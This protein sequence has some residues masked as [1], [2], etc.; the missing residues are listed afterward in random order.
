MAAAGVTLLA[1]I[2]YYWASAPGVTYI[3]SGELAANCASLG[4]AH[5]TGYPLYVCLGRLAVLLPGL[6]AI[7]GCILL[8]VLLAAFA[9]GALCYLINLTSD[10]KSGK[11]FRI[12]SAA[13]ALF[14]SLAPVWWSQGTV[15]EVYGLTLLL[16]LLTLCLAIMF[17][18]QGKVRYLIAMFY[19]WGLSLGSHLSS[20]FLLPAIAYALWIKGAFSRRMR[21]KLMIAVLFGMI[22]LTIYLYLPIRSAHKPFLNWSNPA[23]WQGFLNHI[24]G[25][26][27]RVWM[28]TS[29]DHMVKGIAY[30]RKLIFAQ[31]GL[32]GILLA[33][34]GGIVSLRKNRMVAVMMF[35]IIAADVLYSANYEIPDIDAYYLIAFAATA[36]LV[37]HGIAA[38]AGIIGRLFSRNRSGQLPMYTAITIGLGICLWSFI[39]GIRYQNR[40]GDRLAENG[41][42]NLLDSCPEKAI[43][44]I[45]NWDIYSPW[46]Y[47]R[48]VE[49]R[50]PDVVFI[51][52]ELLRRSW[53]VDFLFRYHPEIMAGARKAADRFL[54]LLKPFETGGRY[55]GAALTEAMVTLI[56]AIIENNK[57]ARPICTNFIGGQFFEFQ[58]IYLPS[59][60]LFYLADSLYYIPSDTSIIDISAWEKGGPLVDNRAKVVLGQIQRVVTSRVIYC[61]NFERQ[62]ESAAWRRLAE[63]I[64]RIM[65]K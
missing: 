11:H 32:V 26:Q 61:Q 62:A 28:F 56:K 27:Y 31:I 44:F 16:N 17:L 7:K 15:N 20:I 36:V 13:A 14:I 6:N 8:S 25:W 34:V 37:A 19:L 55:D 10:G 29:I 65:T 21:T 35:L 5:P 54:Q 57:P 33:V 60:A 24:T 51:D 23:T 30:F 2:V 59:G 42:S 43:V 52:K 40:N 39:S 4:I 18:G 45:E 9:A 50:R 1:A 64:R 49:N 48:Y 38:T 22:A 12:A 47:Y 3:D 53:Y 58:K 46:L 41:V 63:R